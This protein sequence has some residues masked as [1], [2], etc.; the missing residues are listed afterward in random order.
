M[1]FD[2]QIIYLRRTYMKKQILLAGF[3]TFSVASTAF[4]ASYYDGGK[5]SDREG[6]D[7]EVEE[8]LPAEQRGSANPSRNSRC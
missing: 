3:L 1:V 7:F 8:T 4:A 6:P 5:I 2:L